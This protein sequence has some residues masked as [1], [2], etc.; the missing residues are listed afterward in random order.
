MQAC[1]RGRKFEP[2]RGAAGALRARAAIF[3]HNVRKFILLLVLSTV[4]LTFPQD[5]LDLSAPRLEQE[6]TA[7]F[8]F[9]H[10]VN[11]TP[12]LGTLADEADEAYTYV[13]GRTDARYSGK[14]SV[15]VRSM[16]GGPCP[17]R[18]MML[19]RMEGD[20]P[21]SIILFVD[22]T[23]SLDQLRAVLAHELAHLLHADGFT[24]FPSAAGLTAE[25]T[26]DG[27]GGTP[28]DFALVYGLSL[29]ELEKAWLENLGAE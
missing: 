25:A 10:Y 19:E 9:D 29:E 22:E 24:E 2:L 14:A 13:S 21:R 7:H 26:L 18:G 6:T 17:A 28:P 15:A 5:V 3:P 23:T 4:G 8:T 11:V 1:V 20:E 12:A 16:M 27:D